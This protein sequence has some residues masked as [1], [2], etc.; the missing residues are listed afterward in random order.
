MMKSSPSI[1][2][3]FRHSS[4]LRLLTCLPL[5]SLQDVLLPGPGV[6]DDQERPHGGDDAPL[7]TH[8]DG[9]GLVQRQ[10]QSLS[11]EFRV[12]YWENLRPYLLSPY[13]NLTHD[14]TAQL[15]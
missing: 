10:R 9:K 3:C 14:I 2:P 11:G 6:D 1:I 8:L 15:Q 13:S 12:G 7:E 4:H 5:V